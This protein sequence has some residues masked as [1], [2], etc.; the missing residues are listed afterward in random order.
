M[1]HPNICTIHEISETPD[2]QLYLVMAY[3]E[4]ETLKEKIER[5]PLPLV[6]P[7]ASPFRSA[8]ASPKLTP[9]VSCTATSSR[10]T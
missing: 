9:L 10:P 4:G 2:S 6:R 8:K 5:G 7:S 3:Y 1:D